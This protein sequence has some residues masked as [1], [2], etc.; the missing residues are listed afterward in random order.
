MYGANKQ[1]LEAQGR[2]S[3]FLGQIGDIPNR[4]HEAAD[5][6]DIGMTMMRHA[7]LTNGESGGDGYWQYQQ[8]RSR[9]N[10]IEAGTSEILRNIIAERVLGLPRSR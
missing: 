8:L 5:A 4:I 3:S 7:Q 10:T 2:P 1:Y 6:T 9:G